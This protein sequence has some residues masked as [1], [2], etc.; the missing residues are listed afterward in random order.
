MKDKEL[1]SDIKAPSPLVVRVDGRNFKRF[2]RGKELYDEDFSV[3]M[4][5]STEMFMRR[6]GFNC[7]LGYTFSD[8]I[9]VYL[10]NP[11]FKG[12]IEKLNSV[13]PS[14]FASSLSILLDLNNDPITFDSKVIPLHPSEIS[15]YLEWRQTEAFRDFINSYGYYTLRKGGLDPREADEALKGM[16]AAQIDEMLFK[17][18]LNINDTPVWHRR[19]ILVAKEPYETTGYNPITGKEVT[20]SRTRVIQIWSPPDFKSKEGKSLINKL[21]FQQS[22]KNV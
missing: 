3:A 5:T 8:E 20:A 22:S 10:P 6:S 11:P 9:S 7:P 21:V 13:V 18:G 14:F 19:G 15:T 17:R 2:L 16:K 12:R 4:A 1:Y